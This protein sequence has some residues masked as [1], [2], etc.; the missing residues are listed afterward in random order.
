ML[1]RRAFVQAAV[2]AAGLLAQAAVASPFRALRRLG[3]RYSQRMFESM[4]GAQFSAESAAGPMALELI[5][6]EPFTF[7]VD[8]EA[9]VPLEQFSIV[10]R[11]KGKGGPGRYRLR[12]TDMRRDFGTLYLMHSTQEASGLYFRAVFSILV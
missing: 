2:A 4:V 1:S 6:V 12:R 5:A 7:G 11:A 3:A 8:A 9:P 10:F